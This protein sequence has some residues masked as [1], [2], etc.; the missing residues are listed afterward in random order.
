MSELIQNIKSL[1]EISGAGYLDCKNALKENNNNI[2]KSIDYLRKRGLSKAY[3]KSSRIA[4]EGAVGV[5]TNTNKI[6]LIEINTETDFSAKNELFLN[7]LEKIA[8]FALNFNEPLDINKFMETEFENKKISEYFTEIIAKIG[9]NIILRR[10]K[11]FVQDKNTKLFSYIHNSYK[12]NIGKIG[13]VLK[14]E[15]ESLSEETLLLGKGLC[16]HIAATRP[17]SIDVNHLDKDLVVKE[18]EIQLEN[19]KSANKPDDIVNKIL[20]GKMN[21]FYSEVTLLNQNYVLD[22]MIKL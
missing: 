9:E 10:C 6:L 21:K 2:N 8:N 3:K 13:V 5:F 7:F 15:I 19:I 16:M 22:K 4:N 17:I 20:E 12:K 14:A 11:L 1:R 18:R